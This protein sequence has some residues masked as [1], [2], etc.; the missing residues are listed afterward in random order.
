M[1]W[2][3]ITYEVSAKDKGD[4]I[5]ENYEWTILVFSESDKDAKFI[6]L[7]DNSYIFS[8]DDKGVVIFEW[9]VVFNLLTSFK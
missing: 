1:V 5:V 6:G 8:K 3:A 9:W 2:E 7:N 4:N